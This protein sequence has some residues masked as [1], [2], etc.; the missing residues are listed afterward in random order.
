MTDKILL[1]VKQDDVAS[2]NRLSTLFLTEGKFYFAI[3]IVL[4]CCFLLQF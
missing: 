3:I 1:S 2:R 4:M